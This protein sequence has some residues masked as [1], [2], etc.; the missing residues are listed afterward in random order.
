MS[1]MMVVCIAAN[2]HSFLNMLCV[3]VVAIGLGL[4]VMVITSLTGWCRLAGIMARAAVVI[5]FVLAMLLVLNGA[6]LGLKLM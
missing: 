5:G 3:L 1:V 6:I 2:A 4:L